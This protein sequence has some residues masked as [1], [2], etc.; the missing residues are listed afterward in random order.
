[1]PF[2]LAARQEVSAIFSGGREGQDQQCISQELYTR[3]ARLIGHVSVA[4]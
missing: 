3:S 2:V 1:M 4:L